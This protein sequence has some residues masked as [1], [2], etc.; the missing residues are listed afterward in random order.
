MLSGY[1]PFAGERLNARNPRT[2]PDRGGKQSLQGIDSDDSL[3][4][5]GEL[6]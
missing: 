2:E 6:C 4:S 5:D 3:Q 1:V